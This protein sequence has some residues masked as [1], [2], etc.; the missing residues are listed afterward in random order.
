MFQ[1]RII[2]KLLFSN[3]FIV[4]A[5]S[6]VLLLLCCYIYI[7]SYHHITTINDVIEV[8]HT[9]SKTT[10][11][12]RCRIYNTTH[13]RCLPN[14]LFIGASKCGTTSLIN[15][16]SQTI[17]IYLVKRRIHPTDYHREIHRFDR[18]TYQWAIPT[19][20]LLDEWSSSPYLTSI[21]DDNIL[22]HYTP[23]Y[24]YAPTVPFEVKQFYPNAQDLKLI[25]MLRNPV[26]RAWSSY[27]FSNSHLLKQKDQGNFST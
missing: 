16:L 24:L 6:F 17:H 7:I 26:D 22:I 4:I 21:S 1:N 3:V 10:V 19:I 18:Q 13:Y 25:V 5:C 9:I 23:H 11:S 2:K 14:V 12:K 27:W 20:D 15:Y 8:V